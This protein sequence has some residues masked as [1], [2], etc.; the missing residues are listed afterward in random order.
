MRKTRRVGKVD[1]QYGAKSEYVAKLIK[2]TRWKNRNR[3]DSLL[4][5]EAYILSGFKLHGY[6]HAMQMHG[7][8][9]AHEKDYEA[10]LKELNPRRYKADMERKRREEEEERRELEEYER[11]E[12]EEER[13]AR[14]AW[15]KAGGKP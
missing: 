7:L 15:L 1:N 9:S 6:A 12:R 3:I 14:K 2:R 8:K 4:M 13:R 10:I 11:R 5:L